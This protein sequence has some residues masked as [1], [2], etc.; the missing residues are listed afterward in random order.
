MLPKKIFERHMH[1]QKVIGKCTWPNMWRFLSV[2][3]VNR[4]TNSKKC[5]FARPVQR[6][7]AVIMYVGVRTVIIMCVQNVHND[8]IVEHAGNLVDRVNII[9]CL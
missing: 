5:S 9:K 8:K 4:H 6:P 2:L 3:C 1:S 7:C